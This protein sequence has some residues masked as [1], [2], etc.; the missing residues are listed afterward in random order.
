MAA[1]VRR[2]IIRSLALLLL[3]L[4]VGAWVGSYW[5]GIDIRRCWKDVDI[6]GLD[7]GR[8]SYAHFYIIPSDPGWHFVLQSS[9]SNVWEVWDST[10]GLH[11][12]GF[13]HFTTDR[14]YAVTIPLWFPT[15]LSAALLWLVWRKTKPRT[16]GQGFPV[17]P[18]AKPAT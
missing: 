15:L 1:M 13:C 9:N 2:W 8:I 6:V 5:R 12:L 14:M 17:E 3:T 4:C 10:P 16:M 11:G 18:T 7:Y